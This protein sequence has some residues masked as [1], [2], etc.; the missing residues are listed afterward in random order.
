MLKVTEYDQD[1]TSLIM[2]NNP[3]PC[4]TC[5]QEKDSA[6]KYF[7]EDLL[8]KVMVPREV[9][10]SVTMDSEELGVSLRKELI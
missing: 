4:P 9:S 10:G 5:Q 3:P 6:P 8:F 7:S 1:M 2:T